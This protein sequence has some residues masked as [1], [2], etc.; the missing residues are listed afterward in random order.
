M[1]DRRRLAYINGEE[2]QEAFPRY[3][4]SNR[5]RAPSFPRTAAFLASETRP[6]RRSPLAPPQAGIESST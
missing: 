5:P 1:H 3:R 6:Y 2:F 4:A